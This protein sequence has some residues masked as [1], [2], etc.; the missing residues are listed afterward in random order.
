MM[1]KFVDHVLLLGWERELASTAV[2]LLSL[3]DLDSH[4]TAV[5]VW[6]PSGIKTSTAEIELTRSWRATLSWDA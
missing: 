1:A 4:V 2:L 5:Y 6:L 3:C